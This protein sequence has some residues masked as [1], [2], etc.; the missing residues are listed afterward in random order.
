MRGAL[1]AVAL[2]AQPHAE[3]FWARDLTA[4]VERLTEPPSSP[5]EAEQQRLFG[6]VVR[7]LGCEPLA[8]LKPEDSPRL[9]LALLRLE[10]ARRGRLGEAA[11]A[12]A[13]LWRDV[14][15]PLFFWRAPVLAQ[16]K[17]L[18]WPVEEER[19]STEMLEVRMKPSSCALP[20]LPS[21]ELPLLTAELEQE[22]RREV[23]AEVS[24]RLRYHRVSRLLTLG[25]TDEARELAR[26]LSP[27]E[28]NEALRPLAVLA[29]L[30]LGLDSA[31]GYLALV[32]EPR[33]A[34]MRLAL[35]VQ[36]AAHL[37]TQARWKEVLALTEPHAK[38]PDAPT[39]LS[40][41]PLHWDVLYRRALAH[42]ALGESEPLMG[43]WATAFPALASSQD[44]RVEALRALVLNGLARG[45]LDAPALA[46]L[47]DL[48]PATAFPRRLA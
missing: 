16:D 28:M 47:K 4:L 2:A 36:A 41:S 9:P 3:A 17:S 42:Q 20:P 19:W 35:V 5:A 7:F 13:T 12:S 24:H 33:L 30:A 23:G 18:R 40:G 39:R 10:V 6:D 38:G 48:G 14:L 25:R 11:S 29:R 43:L 37:S 26:Q 1:L 46:R 44:L 32:E 45:A 21:D 15:A 8:P 22:A 27:P 31:E 34:D